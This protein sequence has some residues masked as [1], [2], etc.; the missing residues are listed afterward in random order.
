MT[1]FQYVYLSKIYLRTTRPL[2]RLDSTTLSP[3]FASFRNTLEGLATVRAFSAERRFLD[4]MTT[5]LD[6]SSKCYWTYW[7]VNR[8]VLLR[9]DLLGG[10]AVTIVM[11]LVTTIGG[12]SAIPSQDPRTF[13]ASVNKIR[14]QASGGS[15]GFE[16]LAIATA[17]SFTM[18]IY[19]AVRFISQL[20]LDLKRVVF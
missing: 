20:E 1:V 12:D 4:T 17:M 2:K 19:W 15:G 16:G 7:M 14:Q 18:S 8:W 13:W 3:I 6:T 10:F 11:L 5:N 9:F